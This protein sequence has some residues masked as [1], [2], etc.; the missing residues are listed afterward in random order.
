M[1]PWDQIV[2]RGSEGVDGGALVDRLSVE[3]A[4][5][6][7]DLTEWVDW[8]WASSTSFDAT[9]FGGTL[10]DWSDFESD[11]TVCVS[12]GAGLLDPSGNASSAAQQCFPVLGVGPIQDELAFD[13]SASFGRWGDVEVLGSAADPSEL[14]ETECCAALH[15]DELH[16]RGP[17]VA[18][19]LNA[20]GRSVLGV[21]Y[22]WLL[23]EADETVATAVPV[24]R[25]S[26][27][28]GGRA[29]DELPV[30][31]LDAPV[32]GHPRGTEWLTAEVEL[33]GD[34]AEL[35]VDVTAAARHDVFDTFVGVEGD[36]PL[37]NL[38]ATLLID[39]IEL[40]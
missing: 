7:R 11:G 20:S 22:R 38:V 21:R 15:L 29:F 3:A 17:G 34:P 18:L 16:G 40:R 14:C 6:A 19:R 28:A 25:I 9:G 24:L 10:S 39:R 13:G 4:S 35:G 32:D 33:V 37:A 2:V 27:T 26:T 5:T 8:S 23:P 31:E 30:I 1:L 12:I 36:V